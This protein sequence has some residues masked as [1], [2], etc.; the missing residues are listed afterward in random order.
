M[1]LKEI[2][3]RAKACGAELYVLRPGRKLPG[4][5][6]GRIG[7]MAWLCVEPNTDPALINAVAARFDNVCMFERKE[8][9]D[10]VGK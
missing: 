9:E 4:S 1:T 7:K 3:E 8:K 6:R 5:L 2:R 10:E